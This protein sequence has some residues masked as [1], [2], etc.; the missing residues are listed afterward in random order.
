VVKFVASKCLVEQPFVKDEK[1]SVTQHLKNTGTGVSI[2]DFAYIAT[3][4]A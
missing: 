3:D 2:E 4:V 1:V